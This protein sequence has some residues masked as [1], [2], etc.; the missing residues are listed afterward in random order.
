MIR[1]GASC[2]DFV[3]GMKGNSV[4]KL[5]DFLGKGD[6]IISFT[7]AGLDSTSFRK[8]VKNS[9]KSLP[10]RNTIW[11]SI[12]YD[13]GHAVI[14]ALSGGLG[15]RYRTLSVNIPK[16]YRF[17]CMPSVIILDKSGVV[18]FVYNGYSP[19]VMSDIFDWLLQIK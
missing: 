3:V 12:T 8:T 18:Q 11:F 13:T 1:T 6:I 7:D 17:P 10:G 14:E 2:A 4:Y 5:S 16:M 15:L 19:T 9:I